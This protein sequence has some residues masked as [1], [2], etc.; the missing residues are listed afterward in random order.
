MASAVLLFYSYLSRYISNSLDSNTYCLNVIQQQGQTLYE[1]GKYRKAY[2]VF[3]GLQQLQHQQWTNPYHWQHQQQKLLLYYQI[4]CLIHLGKRQEALNICY[5]SVKIC[6]SPIWYLL[7]TDMYIQDGHWDLALEVVRIGY[8][9]SILGGDKWGELMLQERIL[10]EG[11]L[12]QNQYVKAHMDLVE[13]LSYDIVCS[14]FMLLPLKSFVHCSGVSRSWRSLTLTN[15]LFWQH[16]DFTGTRFRPVPST[17][18]QLYLS[19]LQDAPLLSL[20]VHNE[21][22]AQDLLKYLCQTNCSKLFELDWTSFQCSTKASWPLFRQVIFSAGK[23]LTTIRLGSGWFWLNELIDLVSTTTCPY[24]TTLD[25]YGCFTGHAPYYHNDNDDDTN[26][27]FTTMTTTSFLTHDKS[28]PPLSLRYLGLSDVHGLTASHLGT[29]LLRCPHLAELV[30]HNC[31]VNIIPTIGLLSHACPLLQQFSYHQN[32][33]NQFSPRAITTT[34]EPL[35][36]PII[37]FW[38]ASQQHHTLP[39]R[40]RNGDQPTYSNLLANTTSSTN[41]LC[42]DDTGHA[43]WKK[44][45]LIQTKTLTDDLLHS[46]LSGSYHSVQT[47]DLRGNKRLTDHS[48]FNT[49]VHLH[50]NDGV[51]DAKLKN[52]GVA[53]PSLEEC[54]FADCL[55]ITEVGL[56]SLF[57][58][59]PRLRQVDL[60]GLSGVTDV[61]LLSMAL[62]C[63]YLSIVRL[64]HCRS[65][66]D[67]GVRCFIDTFAKNSKKE[68]LPNKDKAGDD[69]GLLQ[70]L[71]LTD[72]YLSMECLAYVMCHIQRSGI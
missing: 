19:R 18:I 68:Q 25:I 17:T 20:L 3:F 66:T 34:I 72:T 63:P 60:S 21:Q 62:H 38:I 64:A 27:R 30:L 48:I 37:P 65:M 8:S 7:A 32:K 69:G 16:L 26:G 13:I 12:R 52:G 28:L 54:S 51:D 39:T 11:H 43:Y 9:S 1:N 53:L 41:K 44:L 57:E 33:S 4:K 40:F 55:H 24:L 46:L 56:C 70:E 45:T 15:P 67:D 36:H 49:M 47:L 10:Y 50:P 2:R 29:I 42:N 35:S 14:I 22:N 59:T 58:H 71:D 6:P 5:T 23:S 61:V 31:P